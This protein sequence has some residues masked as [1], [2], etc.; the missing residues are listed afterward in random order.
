M[1][2]WE[3]S[4]FA[5][6]AYMV[7]DLFP[8]L[9]PAVVQPIIEEWSSR[10]YPDTWAGEQRAIDDLTMMLNEASLSPLQ[11]TQERQ[12]VAR[13]IQNNRDKV[14]LIED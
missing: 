9:E 13:F 10:T 3:L 1:P 12:R 14:Q 2:S 8:T 6:R 5:D 7:I 4:Q 11:L